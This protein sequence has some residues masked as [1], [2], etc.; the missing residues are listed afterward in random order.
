MCF[1]PKSLKG[2][3]FSRLSAYLTVSTFPEIYLYIYRVRVLIFI[4]FYLAVS[5]D[6]F[7]ILKCLFIDYIK[8]KKCVVVF[9]MKKR[10][11]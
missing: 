11:T 2:Y 9:L 4:S 3:Y 1:L 7:H 8:G 6:Y 5:S 10:V